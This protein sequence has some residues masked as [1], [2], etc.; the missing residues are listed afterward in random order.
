LPNDEAEQDRLDMQHSLVSLVL[1][2]AL[3]RA[4][5]SQHSPPQRVLDLGCGTGIW[6]IGFADQFPAS[7]VVGVDLSPIQPKWVPP[8][9]EFYVDDIESEWTYSRAEHFD[10][11]HG[12]AL[13]GSIADWPKLFTQ[14]L[15]NLR[16]GGWLE[17]QEFYSE[18]YEDDGGIDN[19]PA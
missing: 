13:C 17:V 9:C 12:R 10:Y 19:A 18:I 15:A 2:G 16:L 11:I 3:F 4:P 14:S 5:W 7:I 8:N 6:C 1:D